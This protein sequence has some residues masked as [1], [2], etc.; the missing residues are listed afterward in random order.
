MPA[1]GHQNLLCVL[2]DVPEGYL[3]DGGP[4][5]EIF[6]PKRQTKQ[7]LVAGDTVTVF[8]FPGADGGIAAST[9]IPTIELGE[10]ATLKVADVNATGAF[11]EWGLDKQ[12]LLPYAE[13][14]GKPQPG[15]EVLVIAYQDNRGR[16]VASMK[17]DE[18]IEDEGPSL[19]PG[20]ELQVIVANKTELGYKAVVD[21]SY[22]GLLY[23]SE[24]FRP[25]KRG[26][27]CTAYFKKR[28]ADGR[29]DLSLNAPKR[30]AVDGLSQRIL[31]ALEEND[32]FLALGDKSPPEA[33]YRIF[34]E[35]KKSFKQAIG[36]LY[37]D[38]RITIEAGG[39][40]LRR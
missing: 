21:N 36:R 4:L 32:G 23:D 24:V 11:L 35:S 27:R 19:T 10:V 28:R 18:F 15:Q 33:I 13:Q 30:I 6:L 40:R 12:L 3:L 1:I 14:I 9:A 5:G 31:H 34:G 16:L 22:W 39:L 38:G 7:P 20:T 26:Q 8:L 2:K 17:L 29:I 25:L 37:K